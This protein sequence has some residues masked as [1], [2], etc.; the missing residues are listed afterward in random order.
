MESNRKI[1]ILGL[2]QVGLNLSLLIAK[3][4]SVIG[5][6]IDVKRIENLKNGFDIN[7]PSHSVKIP[8]N[9]ILTTDIHDL[10]SA[11]FY[12][13]TVSTHL[14]P[15]KQPDLDALCEV[16]RTLG[17]II[18]QNDIVVYESSIYPGGTEEICIPILEEQSG[19]KSGQDF[20]V[21][22]SPHRINLGDEK[23]QIENISKLLSAQNKNTLNIIKNV[24]NKFLEADIVTVSSI[25]VAETAKLFENINRDVC[26]GLANE[27]AI[28][29][30]KMNIDTHE[31][32]QAAGTKWNFNKYTPGLVGGSCIPVNPYYML[33]KG[34]KL[35]ISF[36]IVK[37]SRQINE[38][39]E[40]Y[41]VSQLIKLL[42]NKKINP[43][44]AK[45]ALLGVTYTGQARI[46]A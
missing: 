33:Y 41:I 7:D 43:F 5:Y 27:L 28:F 11:D 36:D 26:I 35:G 46:P 19:L 20:F 38:Y 24:Y 17:G 18:K 31:V 23:H 4:Q 9:V 1:A 22:F 2:G 8:A 30:H 12:I 10:R 34:N 29:S 37:S 15:D 14:H 6:D 42:L 25:K 39:M 3:K 32:I 16:S 44:H 40:E 45:I 21:G 13:V